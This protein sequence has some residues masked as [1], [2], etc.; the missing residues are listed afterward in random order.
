MV[1]LEFVTA[2]FEG[3]DEHLL[4]MMLSYAQCFLHAFFFHSIFKLIM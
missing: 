4:G 2:H 1:A 3:T